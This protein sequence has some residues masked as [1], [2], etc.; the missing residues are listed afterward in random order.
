MQMVGSAPSGTAR[1]VNLQLV[2]AII[3]YAERYRQEHLTEKPCAL[4]ADWWKAFDFFLGRAC[5]QGR[6]DTVSDRVYESACRVLKPLFEGESRDQN[7]DS[8]KYEDWRPVK[9]QLAERIGK[10]KVGK[11]RDI[12]MIISAFEFLD[13][14]PNRNIVAYTIT[15]IKEGQLQQHY[16]KLQ[17]DITQIGPKV[18]AFYLRDVVSLFDLDDLIGSDSAICLQPVDVWVQKVAEAV[19]LI[20]ENAPM[21]DVQHAI[22][23]MCDNHGISALR[24]N[25]GAWFTGYYAFD[26]LLKLLAKGSTGPKSKR[27]PPVLRSAS[28]ITGAMAMRCSKPS[29][30]IGGD[31]YAVDGQTTASPLFLRGHSRVL[32]EARPAPIPRAA[33]EPGA[34]R[35][36]VNVFDLILIFLNR[37]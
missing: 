19:G 23:S 33:H 6:L 17:V 35:I 21:K 1:N 32:M 24:F 4:T 30:G 25:Q 27:G 12:A 34:H 18:A 13:S 10:G 37:T 2:Q 9:K 29:A 36:E 7:Y 5:Y 11:A 14:L 8:Q 3:S 28:L 22:V 16:N 26:L 20:R 31:G 15:K